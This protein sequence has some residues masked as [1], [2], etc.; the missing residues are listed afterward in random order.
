VST[1]SRPNDSSRP[2]PVTTRLRFVDGDR[3]TNLSTGRAYT[4]QGGAWRTDD[5]GIHGTV[6]DADVRGLLAHDPRVRFRPL[7]G[8]RLRPVPVRFTAGD[9]VVCTDPGGLDR[10]TWTRAAS[11]LWSTPGASGDIDDDLIRTML[12][13]DEV[14]ATGEPFGRFQPADVPLDQPLPAVP[15]DLDTQPT[16]TALFEAGATDGRQWMPFMDLHGTGVLTWLRQIGTDLF[17]AFDRDLEG[18]WPAVM[19]DAQFGNALRFSAPAA[20]L[21]IDATSC[22]A[23]VRFTGGDFART[24]LYVLAEVPPNLKR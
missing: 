13:H 24:F 11:G 7:P 6:A 20:A 19:D 9:Q 10:Y 1:D 23:W 8:A 22:R 15:V 16:D 3:F 5:P 2:G 21:S 12:W 17:A 18:I 14:S 4:R